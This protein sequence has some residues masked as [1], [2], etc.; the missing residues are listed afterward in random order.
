MDI[1]NSVNDTA[2][3]MHKRS[4]HE[5][6]DKADNHGQSVKEVAQKQTIHQAS[7]QLM[8]NAILA[9]QEEVSIEAGDKSMAL[10]YRAAIDAINKELAP[11]LGENAIQKA[12]DDGVD[13]TPEAT[14]DR[15]VKFATNF[16]STHQDQNSNMSFDEQVESFMVK[17][18]GAIDKGF[19]EATEIL[20]G[21]K[22]L[23]GDIAAGVNKTYELIQS[24]LQKFKEDKLAS[25]QTVASQNTE[26]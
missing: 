17:I 7:K 11:S 4:A 1:K 20:S 8:N 22:V 26:K 2:V 23:E 14:A 16:F 6:K 9:A 21:L 15:I 13:F 12:V 18:G 25:Q 3:N 5:V 10:L 19:K 24:S